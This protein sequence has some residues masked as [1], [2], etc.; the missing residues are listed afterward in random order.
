MSFINWGGESPEQRAMRRAL[1]EQALFEQ[2]ARLNQ[3]RNRGGNATFGGAGSGGQQSVE[4][5]PV[6]YYLRAFDSGDDG[7]STEP[8]TSVSNLA[9]LDAVFGPGGWSLVTFE[10][11]DLAVLAQIFS[12]ETTYVFIDGSDHGAEELNVF[13]S[14]TL[15]TIESWVDQG[16]KLFLNAAPNEGG[17][18]PFG[19]GGVT[20]VY[21]SEGEST[22]STN[23]IIADGQ[24]NHPIFVGPGDPGVVWTG[25]SFG[26][27]IVSGEVVPL[28]VNPVP[29]A[30]CAE[31]QWGAGTVIFG[32]MTI[33]EFHDPQPQ[34]TY[35]RQN[36][37]SYLSGKSYTPLM[38]MKR[39]LRADGSRSSR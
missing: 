15:S 11:I 17:N 19:F 37:H 9:E 21:D 32:G 33:T 13:L 23:T 10:S 14:E 16:G 2:V 35:L 1:E 31:L 7:E 18:I 39:S 5:T 12:P 30:V 34:V 3:A 36:I 20:L 29:D 8:W 28:I 22:D 38:G 24:E 25:N 4:P 27:A 26:H 6:V